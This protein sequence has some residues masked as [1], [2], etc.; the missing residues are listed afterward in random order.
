[1][2]FTSG[3]IGSLSLKNRFIKTFGGDFSAE[4]NGYCSES[5]SQYLEQFARGGVALICTAPAAI[6]PNFRINRYQLSISSQEAAYSYKSLIKRIHTY[7]ARVFLYPDYANEVIVKFICSVIEPETSR[8]REAFKGMQEWITS[9]L[10]EREIT[11]I[12]SLYEEAIIRGREAG[13]DGIF[14]NVSF[15]SLL[16]TMSSL[17][18]NQRKDEWGGDLK[19]RLRILKEILAVCKILD[20]PVMVRWNLKDYGPDGL[21]ME[22]SI[23]ACQLLET[24]GADAL[25]LAAFLSIESTIALNRDIEHRKSLPFTETSDLIDYY[26]VMHAFTENGFFLKRQKDIKLPMEYVWGH[27]YF[28]V[29][30]I[31]K[32]LKIPVSLLGGVRSLKTAETI[33]DNGIADFISLSRALIHNPAQCRDFEEG[34]SLYS[35]CISCN[36]CMNEVFFSMKTLHALTFISV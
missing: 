18:F 8:R 9:L 30:P 1:M 10:R 29:Q 26:R 16:E 6:Q 22:E 7:G 33:L 13:F 21:T 2:I 34:T 15:G 3:N 27:A 28:N 24:Y 23:E 5:Y 32:I 36:R 4:P 14:L 17:A 20:F 19:N 31:K 25:E 11:K 35:S 12:I